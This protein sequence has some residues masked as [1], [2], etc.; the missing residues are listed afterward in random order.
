MA[1]YC[2]SHWVN[3]IDNNYDYNYFKQQENEN[4]ENER[5]REEELKNAEEELGSLEAFKKNGAG[6]K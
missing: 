2:E 5:R 3:Y 6:P 4:E 1:K